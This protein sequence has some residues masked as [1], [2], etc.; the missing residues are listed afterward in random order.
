MRTLYKQK[1]NAENTSVLLKLGVSEC[2]F[3][4]IG[5]PGD[6][7]N[8]SFKTHSHVEYEIHMVTCGNQVYKIGTK[9]FDICAGDFL[10][11][12]PKTQHKLEYSSENL[13][14]FS[15][16]FKCADT[17]VANACFLKIPQEVR[18]CID[19]VS[20]ESRR[21]KQFSSL[22]VE[23]RTFE[24]LVCLLRACGYGEKSALLSEESAD[25]RFEL[26]KSFIAENIERDLSVA[27]VASYCYLSNKQLTRIFNTELGIS[28]AKYINRE[29]ME[30]IGEL[31]RGGNMSIKQISDLFCYNNEYYFNTSFKKYFGMPPASYRRMFGR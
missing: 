21:K 19:F 9:V 20:Q 30:K 31:V 13:E 2:I 10:L 18:S 16:L 1:Q 8:V 27:D 11:I 6:K 17:P 3:K 7:R 29:K 24:M 15:V 25:Y 12:P 14:K 4:E 23:N 22:L 28:P 26:A 5:Q